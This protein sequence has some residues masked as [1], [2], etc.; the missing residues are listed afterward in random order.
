MMRNVGRRRPECGK[1]DASKWMIGMNGAKQ[2]I[3]D[4]WASGKADERVGEI[5]SVKASIVRAHDSCPSLQVKQAL[6]ALLQ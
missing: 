2:K 5:L 6:F 4:G 3:R 1:S